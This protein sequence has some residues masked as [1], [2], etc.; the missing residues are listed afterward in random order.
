MIGLLLNTIGHQMISSALLTVEMPLSVTDGLSCGLT[1]NRVQQLT[2]G[3]TSHS[4]LLCDVKQLNCFKKFSTFLVAN[5]TMM[6][7]MMSLTL[8]LA[9]HGE[10]Y[11]GLAQ[12][13]SC[14]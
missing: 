3:K 10:T 4:N 1:T 6:D 11:T 12:K 7:L 14:Q 13:V 5:V 8:T 2:L 9:I